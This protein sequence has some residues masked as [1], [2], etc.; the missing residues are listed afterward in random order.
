MVA[1]FLVA[2]AGCRYAGCFVPFGPSLRKRPEPPWTTYYLRAPGVWMA[3]PDGS[4]PVPESDRVTRV[5]LPRCQVTIDTQSPGPAEVLAA[6]DDTTRSHLKIH[7]S[8]AG[9]TIEGIM[10][11]ESS[12]MRYG[13]HEYR[14]KGEGF[15][16]CHGYHLSGDG[17]ACLRKACGSL[18]AEQPAAF[19]ARP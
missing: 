4:K 15:V 14:V 8:P 19:A 18:A 2:L 13:V 3:L 9:A 17:I 1:S 11:D 16:A 10:R 12:R 7:R 5:E 6:Q